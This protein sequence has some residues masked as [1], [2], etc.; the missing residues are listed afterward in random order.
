MPKLRSSTLA[1][2]GLLSSLILSASVYFTQ[3]GIIYT[4]VYST[5]LNLISIFQLYELA[6]ILGTI[7]V[8]LN[9]SI[10]NTLFLWIGFTIIVSLLIRKMN[11]TLTVVSTAILLPGGTWML[12][13]IKYAPLVGFPF[14][15]L[16]SFLLWKILIPLGLTLGLAGLLSL[17]FFLIQRRQPVEAEVPKILHFIC[18]SCGAEYRSQPLICVKCG[19]E[20]TIEE[21]PGC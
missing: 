8:L 12:F 9:F 21:K 7:D 16:F 18:T 20:G 14:G 6:W 3:P 5:Y 1:P 11:A 10:L 2:L 13:A 15:F 17:P 19:K 4:L